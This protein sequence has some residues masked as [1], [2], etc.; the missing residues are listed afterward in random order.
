MIDEM[1]AEIFGEVAFGRLS[2]SRRAQLIAR[3][4]F[5]LLGTGLSVAGAVHFMLNDRHGVN[6]VL[7]ANMVLMFVLLGCFCLFNIALARR[8][9]WPGVLFVV[10]FIGLFVIRIVFGPV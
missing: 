8:W 3:V 1:L 9:R 10:S 4:F 2:K 5:G 6:A 7:R